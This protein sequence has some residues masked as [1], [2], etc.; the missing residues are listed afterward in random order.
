MDNSIRSY[1][2]PDPPWMLIDHRGRS[3]DLSQS[4]YVCFSDDQVPNRPRDSTRHTVRDAGYSWTDCSDLGEISLL[5]AGIFRALI[6]MV[7]DEDIGNGWSYNQEV[8]P[9][10]HKSGPVLESSW[11]KVEEEITWKLEE[12]QG[13]EEEITWKLEES[14]GGEEEIT[15][16]LEESQGG[17]EEITWKLEE[18]QGGEEEITWKLEESQGGEEEITWKLEE[19]Q[20]GEEEITWKLEESQGGEEEITWK[21]EESQGGRGDQK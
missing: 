18:S 13:G 11:Q 3:P 12:S 20:G 8:R 5:N 7:T 17:E 6:D 4:S 15:W 2:K 1:S 9:K 19:S 21:L 10:H 14:Q 16:K